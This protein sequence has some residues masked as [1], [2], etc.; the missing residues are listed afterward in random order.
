MKKTIGAALALLILASSCLKA[1]DT[2]CNYDECRS[3]FAPQGELDFLDSL[4]TS[5]GITATPHC[6]GGFYEIVNPG[7]G[8]S[9]DP[10]SNVNVIS[11][12]WVIGGGRF[13]STQYGNIDMKQVITGWRAL[14]PKIR[15]G[16]EIN[17]YLPPT[18]AYGGSAFA[19][20]PANS[21]LKFNVKL[22][23]VN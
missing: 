9:I 1:K 19:S 23:G 5:Q 18:M 20:I 8:A 22:I 4:L 14:L 2:G 10:C 3:A 6:T 15:T 12:G 11:Q 17:M 16:G 7:T 13:D 21:Y